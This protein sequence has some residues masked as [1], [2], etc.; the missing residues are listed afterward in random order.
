MSRENNQ[1]TYGTLALCHVRAYLS[2]HT[3]CL[4]LS[5][6][7]LRG[8]RVDDLDDST[9]TGRGSTDWR[10]K[11]SMFRQLVVYVGMIRVSILF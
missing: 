7:L 2:I 10:C 6:R 1:V 5:V 3:A 9:M 11:L 8:D 4:S